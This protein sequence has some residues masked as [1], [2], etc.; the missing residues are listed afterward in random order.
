M[1]GFTSYLRFVDEGTDTYWKSSF[2]S[3]PASAPWPPVIHNDRPIPD[4][5]HGAGIFTNIGPINDPVL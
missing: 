2:A 1:V 5:N 3:A 4:A